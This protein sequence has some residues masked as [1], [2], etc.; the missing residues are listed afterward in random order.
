MLILA[1]ESEVANDNIQL[2]PVFIGSPSGLEAE[3]TMF[4]DV[5]DELNR[6]H[7]R[8]WGCMLEPVGWEE[9]LPGRGRPQALINQELDRCEYFI[10]VMYDHWGSQTA[11]ENPKYTSGFEEE[12][13]RAKG[14]V[15]SGKMNDMAVYF[16]EVPPERL[17]DP[18]DSL[19]R[20]LAFKEDCFSKRDALYKEYSSEAD[21]ETLIRGRLTAIGWAEFE[22]RQSELHHKVKSEAPPKGPTAKPE[23]ESEKNHLFSEPTRAFLEAMAQREAGWEETNAKEVARMRLV[24][25]SVYRSGND[26][27]VLGAHDANLLFRYRD[28][29]ELG[30]GEVRGLVESG[31]AGFGGQNIPLWHWVSKYLKDEKN[32]ESLA[33]TAAIADET[34]QAHAIRLI[35]L[36]DIE[37]PNIADF[38]SR[39]ETIRGWMDEEAKRGVFSE[40][41]IYLQ[42]NSK[43]E[44]LPLLEEIYGNSS[45][46]H[47]AKLGDLIVKLEARSG[48]TR[49]LT[50]AL[51]LAIDEVEEETAEQ[52]FENPASLT[53]ELLTECVR[54]PSVAIRQ[55]AASIL[56]DRRA[57]RKELAD[58][59]LSDPDYYVRYLAALALHHVG[60]PLRDD[61]AKTALTIT[62]RNQGRGLFPSQSDTD[63][64][65][66]ERYRQEILRLK[67]F[68]QLQDEYDKGDLYDEEPA[69]VL[70]QEHASKIKLE[71]RKQ[72]RDEF[73]GY[74]DKRLGYFIETF[75]PEDKMIEIARKHIPFLQRRI[76]TAAL[77]ALCDLGQKED[78]ELVRHTLDNAEIHFSEAT[79]RYL[80]K[81]GDWSD[82]SR[83]KDMTD[84]R[85]QI[86]SLL[87]IGFPKA[88]P[89][90]AN[91]ML[92]IGKDRI[93]D[94]LA[95]DMERLLR[96]ELLKQLKKKN[97]ALMSDEILLQALSYADDE[98]RAITALKCVQFLP[99][100]RIS[101][102]LKTYVDHD[103]YRF[104]NSIHWLDL[105]ASL[106]RD[107][108]KS[109]A[110]KELARR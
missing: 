85:P 58:T 1:S 15:S 14:H 74:F 109:V 98:C 93:A 89:Q 18:G 57:I 10:G 44:D 52:V 91:A 103:G 90:K 7:S 94:L 8:H 48:A 110:S 82:L 20:V 73:K 23:I 107:T 11:S 63:K 78:L 16:K 25:S 81:F 96:R 39:E 38:F 50:R 75:G 21:F 64:E 77:E 53:T 62:N 35:S 88:L 17:R 34:K 19:K 13:E 67:E 97:V 65:F 28:T 40:A 47:Q 4:R 5:I 6:D 37:P 46:Q 9:T 95:E 105:G 92:S 42:E 108:A 106:P 49:A 76:T 99:K 30:N 24:A 84:Y 102:L 22:K 69:F 61:L 71:L 45:S 33:L 101:S 83:I 60:S 72:L 55:K 56:Y 31:I 36:L 26:E 68:G 43:P 66:L 104:Y 80:G 100:A 32:R 59:L 87:A 3:R 41:L 54:S 79:L 12:F 86:L 51:E 70:Y 29:L 2:I 27:T